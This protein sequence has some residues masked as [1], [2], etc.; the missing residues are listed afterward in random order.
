MIMSVSN[1]SDL[2]SAVRT[3]LKDIGIFHWKQWQGPMSQPK[4]VSDVIGIVDGRMFAIELKRPGWKPPKPGK[5]TAWKHYCQQ[6]F[7]LK[8][9]RENGGIAFFAQSIEEVI[10]GLGIRDKFLF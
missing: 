8:T 3:M 6:E 10:D 2:T 7:F 1:E 4:G 5:T 9:V